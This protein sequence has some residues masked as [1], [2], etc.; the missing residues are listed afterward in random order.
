M[1][2]PWEPGPPPVTLLCGCEAQMSPGDGC[3]VMPGSPGTPGIPSLFSHRGCA[4]RKRL[5]VCGCGGRG[6]QQGSGV[7]GA[8]LQLMEHL[9]CCCR[10]AG[11]L[12][13]LLNALTA[14]LNS[15]RKGK[16]LL[17]WGDPCFLENNHTWGTVML[18]HLQRL[19]LNL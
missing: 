8:A 1:F 5:R 10:S 6:G 13:P 18:P 19:S 9:C 3:E 14:G 17:S 11:L 16:C 4:G 15:S 12:I 2:L 7:W